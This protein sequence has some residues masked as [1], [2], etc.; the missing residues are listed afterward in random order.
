MFQVCVCVHACVL[1]RVRACVRVCV[2]AC[3]CTRAWMHVC[4]EQ[5]SC[6]CGCM[7]VEEAGAGEWGE[8]VSETFT[9]LFYIYN[10]FKCTILSPCVKAKFSFLCF[11]Y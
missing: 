4:S 8:N 9:Y 2:H 3:V 7:S 10:Y 5:Y 11:V 1:A 6:V